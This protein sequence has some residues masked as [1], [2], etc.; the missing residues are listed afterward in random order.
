MELETFLTATNHLYAHD[1]GDTPERQLRALLATLMVQHDEGFGPYSVMIPGSEIVL[2]TDAP[3]HDP[4]LEDDVI[5]KANAQQ[6]CISFY[7]SGLSDTDSAQYDR[8]AA[9]TGGKVVNSIDHTSFRR[10]D[11]E[12]N[13]GQCAWFYEL[14]TRDQKKRAVSTSSY[15]TE[16]RCH[17]FTTSLL[18]DT[19]TVQSYT[20]QASMIVTKPNG[21]ELNIITNFRGDKVYRDTAPLS[22]QWSVC[23]GTGT[24]TISVHITDSINPILQY[25][26]STSTSLGVSLQYS[27]PPACKSCSI[28]LQIQFCIYVLY[29][30][31]THVHYTY[32]GSEATLALETPQ[33]EDIGN[34]SIQLL[35]E[36]SGELLTESPLYRCANRLLG[37]VLFPQDTVIFRAVGNDVNGRPLCALLSKTA[38]FVQSKFEVVMEGDDPIEVDQGQ[39]L[40]INLTVHNHDISDTNYNFTAEPVTG[41]RVAFRPTSLT[42]PVGGSGSVSMII[43]QLGA[44]AGSSYTFTVTVTDGC[45]SHSKN[46]S[47]QI[48][49]RIEQCV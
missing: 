27:P 37:S 11:D 48:P 39:T 24:L 9:A 8:I 26:T 10:F 20:T 25:L 14:P 12:H 23:V 17:Y 16:Q 47:I 32:S 49:V 33:I 31:N 6:V 15:D 19:L 18:T 42:V 1:G 7:L 30:Y 34:M 44:E 2:L 29:S 36:D 21:E 45:A 35:H 3:S 5:T 46:V 13:Y 40:S 28:W 43:W 4:D 22:G 38:T 41:F